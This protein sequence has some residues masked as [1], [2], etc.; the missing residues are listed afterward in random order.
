MIAISVA[1]GVGVVVVI[2]AFVR[3]WLRQDKDPDLGAV[4]EHWIAEQRL[5]RDRNS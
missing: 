2:L 5:G 3:S 1:I 4:S